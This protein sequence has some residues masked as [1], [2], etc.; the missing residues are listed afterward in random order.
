MPT[1]PRAARPA[2]PGVLAQL[3][4][5]DPPGAGVELE[6]RAREVLVDPVLALGGPA[7]RGRPS[8]PRPPR[9]PSSARRQP[10]RRDPGS[11]LF[12]HTSTSAVVSAGSARYVEQRGRASALVN[13]PTSRATTTRRSVRNGGVWA[14]STTD[15]RARSR[16]PSSSSTSS[17]RSP[18][19]TSCSTSCTTAS[20]RSTSSSP[21]T[22]YTARRSIDRHRGASEHGAPS[23]RPMRRAPRTSW[24]RR[25]RQPEADAEGVGGVR[26]VACDRR[27]RC[28]AGGRGSACS[29]PTGARVAELGQPVRGPQQHERLRLGLAEVEAGV[30][31]DPLAR[32]AGRLGLLRAARAGSPRTSATTSSYAGSGSGTRGAEPD[33]GGHHRRAGLGR[34]RRG[35]RGRRSR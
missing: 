14:A 23:R 22:R 32:D 29:T 12:S 26:R 3:L 30:D 35:S 31:H 20:S 21:L 1:A 2:A 4:G 27:P 10:A 6:P 24:A 25:M 33:V 13:R 15:G 28:R 11:G 7:A 34:H 19:P 16:R 8:P 9:A 5:H 18:S 17:D